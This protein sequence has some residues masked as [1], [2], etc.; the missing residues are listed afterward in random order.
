MPHEGTNQV[1]LAAHLLR[2][3]PPMSICRCLFACLS[4][5]D[6]TENGFLP[7]V[8]LSRKVKVRICRVGLA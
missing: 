5:T 4:P 6:F 3:E 8:S 2:Y 7:W 1:V